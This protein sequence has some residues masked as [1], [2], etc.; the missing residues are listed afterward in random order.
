MPLGAATTLLVQP[1]DRRRGQALHAKDVGKGPATYPGL[2]RPSWVLRSEQR[3][4]VENDPVGRPQ[5]RQPALTAA[6]WRGVSAR[7]SGLRRRARAWSR[8][9]TSAKK[10]TASSSA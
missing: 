1:R 6:A 10:S 3:D 7:R 8:P 2:R 5:R 9:K 4:L